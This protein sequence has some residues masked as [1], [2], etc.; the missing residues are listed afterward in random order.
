MRVQFSA[1]S[2]V[3]LSKRADQIRALMVGKCPHPL[4]WSCRDHQGFCASYRRTNG[5]KSLIPRRKHCRRWSSSAIRVKIGRPRTRFVPISS[6][7]GSNVGLLP[8]ISNREPLGPKESCKVL[9]PA[10]YSSWSS[11]SMRMIPIM[12]SGKWRKLSPPGSPSSLSESRMFCQ[13]KV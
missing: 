2:K 6:P 3:H 12:F 1:N 10:E 11:R 8:V 9:T 7:L 4:L 5:L 13:T